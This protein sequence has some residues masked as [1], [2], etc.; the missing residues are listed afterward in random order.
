MLLKVSAAILCLP[1]NCLV[2]I[3]YYME[4][5]KSFW[6]TIVAIYIFIQRLTYNVTLQLFIISDTCPKTM[7]GAHIDTMN[8]ARKAI[9]YMRRHVLMTFYLL[10]LPK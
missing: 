7:K 4:Y 3:S 9:A 10:N 1:S 8:D 6:I 5:M 2:F